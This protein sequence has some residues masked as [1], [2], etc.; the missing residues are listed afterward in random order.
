MSIAIGDRDRLGPDLG[1]Q[2]LQ[3][4]ERLFHRRALRGRR[5]AAHH[6]DERGAQAADIEAEAL[7]ARMHLALGEVPDEAEA[8]RGAARVGEPRVEDA[9]AQPPRRV[10]LRLER[11]VHRAAPDGGVMALAKDLQAE[12]GGAGRG[13]MQP[14]VDRLQ[15]GRVDAHGPAR[16]LAVHRAKVHG[17]CLADL[18]ERNPQ[19]QLQARGER[20]LRTGN[21][22]EERGESNALHPRHYE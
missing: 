16:P 18:L 17:E 13:D 19:R 10:E 21:K 9:H 6:A 22:K 4:S 12:R 20:A 3:S 1:W 14:S 5:R 2:E 8:G 7:Q 15:R 11:K